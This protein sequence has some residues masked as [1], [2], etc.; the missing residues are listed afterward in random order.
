M[1]Q[2]FTY[3]FSPIKI[4]NVTIKNRIVIT[5]HETAMGFTREDNDG[6]RYLEYIRARAKGGVGLIICGGVI[7]TE[8]GEAM[9]VCAP[10]HDSFRLKLRRLAD[11]CHEHGAKVFFQINHPGR[12]MLSYYSLK[13]TM[14]FSALPSPDLRE[15]PHEMSINEIEEIIDGFAA[16]AVDC[17]EAGLDGVELH[18]T[19]GYLLQ[20]SW[21]WWA[22][23]RKD[24]Y[25]EQMAFAYEL[26]DR[27]R[28]AV[29][30]DFAVGIRISSDDL[31]PGGLNV[32]H[33]KVIAQ[34]L[35]ATGK[36]D[37]INTSEGALYTTYTYAIGSSYVPLGAFTPLVGKI[38][39]GLNKVPIIAAGR[40]KDHVQAE[41]VLAD[42][43][44]DLVGMVRAHIVDPEAT[45]KA[46]AGQL[47][48][49]RKCIA[50]NNCIERVF[51]YHPMLCAQTPVT[52]NEREFGTLDH[53][54]N[55]KKIL[56]V[57]AGPAG[58]ECARV[59]ALRGHQVEVYEKESE[60]GGQVNLICRDPRRL[61]YEDLKRYQIRQ[62]EK[63]GV[64]IHTKTE[65]TEEL[66]WSKEPK[67]LVI[68]TGSVPRDLT[69]PL[70]EMP[71]PG[72]TEKIVM[73]LFDV[74]KEPG[75]VGNN[76]LIYDRLGDLRAL[77]TAL[78]LS[79]MGKQVEMATELF[80]AG[81]E[82]G[83]TY[84]PFFYDQLYRRKV[85]FTPSV[86]VAEI[87]GRKVDLMNVFNFQKETRADVDTF[88]PVVPQRPVDELWSSLRNEIDEVHV[89]GDAASPRNLMLAIHDGFHLGRR[90]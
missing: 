7:A 84:L 35:E 68:A 41:K 59:A 6:G 86:V 44:A 56:V 31:Q 39:E 4:G 24:K 30:K 33:M 12:Q 40:I 10:A 62:L 58:M 64:P 28:A 79:E 78:F 65:V 69:F 16:Y 55:P 19:H 42:G 67:C 14:A 75:A 81:M 5:P 21:S 88:I 72:C 25:G 57:G 85:T 73:N 47:E 71:V 1:S 49:I 52:G 22:N 83:Y 11:A 54:S 17:K 20:Q 32:D 23:R 34:Q 80:F 26:I 46:M 50:C 36:I 13:A 66:I 89:I 15:M 82:A 63:L 3:L 43:H 74:Y 18:G 51:R 37:L 76:V 70:S 60:P 77:S 29:G 90:L 53:T 48:D 9:G 2:Q 61:D 27:V 38:R 8:S 45:N 87:S